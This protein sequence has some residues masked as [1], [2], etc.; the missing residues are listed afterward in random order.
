MIV[1]TRCLAAQDVKHVQEVI[2][3]MEGLMRSKSILRRCVNL[4]RRTFSV[5]Q[6]ESQITPECA[7]NPFA[8]LNRWGRGRC[9]LGGIPCSFT[10][11]VVRGTGLPGLTAGAARFLLSGRTAAARSALVLLAKHC[12]GIARLRCRCTNRAAA[13]AR[14]KEASKREPDRSKDPYHL[15][16]S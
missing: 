10:R 12:R 9:R 16:I 8:Q 4:N 2:D 11:T 3:R 6:D 5:W 7:A 1:W 14:P 15:K 13:N